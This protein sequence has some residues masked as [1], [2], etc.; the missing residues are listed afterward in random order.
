MTSKTSPQSPQIFF[1]SFPQL[2]SAWGDDPWL[3]WTWER[4]F[5]SKDQEHEELQTLAQAVVEKLEPLS[6]LAEA[7]PPQHH[8]WDAWGHRQDLILTHPAWDEMKHFAARWGLVASGYER[9]H[10]SLSRV[11]Q[12]LK[13]YLYHPSSALFSCPLAMTDGAARV[14]EL[15]SQDSRFQ[16]FFSHLINRNP[17]DFWTSGQWMTETTGGSD[18]SLTQTLAF[19]VT[20]DSTSANPPTH[21]LYGHKWFTSATTSEM[22]LALARL[23]EAPSG[24]KGLSLFL[25]PINKSPTGGLQGIRVVRL[26]NKFGTKALPTAELELEACP[27]W[28]VQSEGIKAITPMLHITR[29]YNSVCALSSLSRGVHWLR[30]YSGHRRAFGSLIRD[31]PLF[32]VTL[33]ELYAIAWGLGDWLWSLIQLWGEQEVL[34]TAEKA[35]LLRFL[36]PLAKIFSARRSVD[37]LSI[38]MESFGGQGYIED[39]PI[40]R[41]VANA[42]VFPIWEGTAHVLTQELE[43]VM[44]KEESHKLWQSSLD[45]QL[46]LREQKLK[47]CLD[48][49]FELKS[50]VSPQAGL[51]WAEALASWQV[52]YELERV[53]HQLSEK[54]QNQLLDLG[55]TRLAAKEWYAELTR[56]WRKKTLSVITFLTA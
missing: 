18:V 38:C 14:L 19:P 15:N 52:W 8:P 11:Y 36:N 48:R 53:A 49:L 35:Q 31:L 44:Q 30:L 22:A 42:H 54:Q 46:L 10:G 39:T 26:K 34:P 33:R 24:N 12:M 29:L 47:E 41:L 27:A 1:Q 43:R 3:R 45:H 56:F 20:E 28:L 6:V 9:S 21:R 16:D 32:Q 4:Y 23:P 7:F 50:S 51:R 13:L 2:T 17:Q 55:F 25:V 37:A 5:P 40:P